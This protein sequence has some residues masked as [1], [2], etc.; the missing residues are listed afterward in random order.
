[1]EFSYPDFPDNCQPGEASGPIF[2]TMEFESTSAIRKFRM[3]GVV[4]TK[5]MSKWKVDS[6]IRASSPFCVTFL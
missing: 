2:M 6:N 4:D 5:A 3:A 1:M